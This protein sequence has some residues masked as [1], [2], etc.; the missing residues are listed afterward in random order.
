MLTA[1]RSQLTAYSPMTNKS[2]FTSVIILAITIL[3]VAAISRRGEP[4]VI[5]TNLENLPMEISGFKATEDFF[6]DS[7]YKEL[8]A[9][10]HVYRHYRNGDGKQV[11]LY[12]GYYGTAKGGRT[13]HNPYAC[14]PGA[15]WGIVDSRSVR[16][17]S[18]YHTS[19]VN[20]N[21][22]LARKGETYESVLH[23]YQSAG[24]KVLS[25]GI[26][27]NIERFKGR[28]FYNRNDGAFVRVSVLAD[29]KGIEEANL[30]AKSFA[31]KILDLLPLFWPIER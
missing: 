3:L 13:G 18:R 31:G 1:Y 26:Q 9:D 11:N 27:Q 7:V 15:G 20:V 16:V 29:Q 22:V 2:F 30:L 4:V 10:K 12:I 23:W 8:N 28:I 17:N 6:P 21:Y 25:T 14:L 24:N 5:K 19:T